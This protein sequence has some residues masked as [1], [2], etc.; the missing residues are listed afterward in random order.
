MLRRMTFR[1]NDAVRFHPSISPLSFPFLM[2]P[3]RRW[4]GGS[5][6]VGRFSRSLAHSL[7]IDCMRGLAIS[8]F[9]YQPT[10]SAAQTE[11]T[12][13]TADS[14]AS[15]THGGKPLVAHQRDAVSKVQTKTVPHTHDIM[16]VWFSLSSNQ[17]HIIFNIYTI[18]VFKV[19]RACSRRKMNPYRDS[20]SPPTQIWLAR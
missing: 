1:I 8:L 17:F 15:V 7:D 13:T 9:R 20:V 2:P 4:S 6:F 3:S 11:T 19:V 5:P 10:S 14:S 18:S 16:S 12:T